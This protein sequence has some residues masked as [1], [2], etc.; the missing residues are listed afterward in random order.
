M[1]DRANLIRR[2]KYVKVYDALFSQITSGALAPGTCLPSEPDLARQMGV[3][4]ATLRQALALLQDDHLVQ[5]IRGKGNY[6]MGSH[7]YRRVGL[8][9]L[10]HPIYLCCKEPVTSTELEMRIDV[11]SDYYIKNLDR[12]THAVVVCNRWYRNQ[13]KVIAYSFTFIPIEVTEQAALDLAS[14]DALKQFL[15]KGLY[16]LAAYSSLAISN[17]DTG[18]FMPDKHQMP[19][20]TD[21]A[22]L[23][24]VLYGQ[25]GDVLAVS[26]HYLASENCEIIVYTRPAAAAIE[27]ASQDMEGR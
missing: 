12:Q 3:S 9:T 19:T 18:R 17:T 25:N 7:A 4:R 2:P 6:V 26:K 23:Y 10:A 5:N 15:E 8:E 24:E 21:Y 11:P 22:M 14:N 27:K 16:D 20:A 1:A 13:N